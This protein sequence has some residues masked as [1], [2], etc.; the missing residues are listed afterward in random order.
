MT[1]R[2][3]G[4][5]QAGGATSDHGARTV[6]DRRAPLAAF[7][8]AVLLVALVILWWRRRA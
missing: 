2:D 4:G 1:A 3:S 5:R 7:G 8:G 6:Q